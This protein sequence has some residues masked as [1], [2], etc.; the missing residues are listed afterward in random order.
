MAAKRPASV[1][2]TQA[3]KR[4]GTYLALIVL[5]VVFAFPFVWM[6]STSLKFDWQIFP[7]EGSGFSMNLFPWPMRWENY[8]RALQ[9]FPFLSY[10]YNTL[11]ICVFTVIGTVLSST[12]V[13]YGFSRI[14]WRGRNAVFIMVL[15][16]MMIP[17]Q[18][19]LLPVFILFRD[20]G[21]I[22][23][24]KPLIV[25][26]FFGSA[27]YIFML[28]QFFMTLPGEL[29]DAARI[30]G[31]S[32]LSIL[33]RIIAPLAK[34]AI[35]TVALFTFM[36]AWLDFMGP[37]VYL[38]DE[39]LYT[40]ALGLNAFLGR[41]GADWS[42]LMAAGTVVVAPIIILFFLTQKTFIKGIALTGMK[43]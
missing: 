9:T 24:Y 8:G 38:N 21:W 33:T 13:A 14:Q 15:A 3:W 17:Y 28:R 42:G 18:V 1:K 20:L 29:S 16:T 35:A 32:E 11:Y 40:L 7:K 31:C 19:T 23:T 37:L 26:A 12:L 10:L 39:R 25:P 36:G 34:P 27:F 2:K 4:A 22:G 41:Y 30:D 5:S 43:G 6:I